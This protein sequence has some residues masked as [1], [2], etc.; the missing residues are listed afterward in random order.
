MLK[1]HPR[2][3][4]R[5]DIRFPCDR[6]SSRLQVGCAKRR[7]WSCHVPRFAQ[8]LARTKPRQKRKTRLRQKPSQYS[9]IAFFEEDT[10]NINGIP[11]CFPIPCGSKTGYILLICN[12]YWIYTINV[13]LMLAT[14]EFWV[15]R[16]HLMWQPLSHLNQA[17]RKVSLT[18]WYLRGEKSGQRFLYRVTVNIEKEKRMD[19][20]FFNS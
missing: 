20:G 2:Q 12:W 14:E 9:T 17:C 11:T 3:V 4:L 5:S 13:V 6:R 19:K 16:E 8:E 7:A 15:D 1:I 10:Y 18:S